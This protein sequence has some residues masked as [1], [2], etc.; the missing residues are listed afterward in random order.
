MNFS[1]TFFPW[2][3]ALFAMIPLGLISLAGLFSRMKIDDFCVVA[4]AQQHDAWGTMLYYVNSWSGS[5]TR[6]L[7]IG[8]LGPLDHLAPAIAPLLIV[9]LWFCSLS[10]LIYEGLI[11][12]GIA[13]SRR[14]AAIALS[15]LT[16]SA[17]I[18]AFPSERAIYWYVANTAYALPFAPLSAFLALSVRAARQGALSRKALLA[19]AIICFLSGGL[20]EAFVS[21]QLCFLACSLLLAIVSLRGSARYS[22]VLMLGAGWAASLAS[23]IL[24]LLSPGVVKR[25]L[26]VSQDTRLP[27]VRSLPDLLAGT[28]ENTFAFLS[29]PEIT[30]GFLLLTAVGMFY[31]LTRRAISPMKP[32]ERPARLYAPLLWIGIIVQLLCLPILWAYVSDDPQFFGRFSIRYAPFLV[33]NLIAIVAYA[34]I[35]WGRIRANRRLMLYGPRLRTICSV[36]LVIVSTALALEI[37]AIRIYAWLYLLCTIGLFL[38][39][40]IWDS[41]ADAPLLSLRRGSFLLIFCLAVTWLCQASVAATL[42]FARGEV[43]IRTMTPGPYLMMISGLVWG[44]F[45][46]YWLKGLLQV[47]ASTRIL[48]TITELA[49]VALILILAFAMVRDQV[50][51]VALYQGHARQW[52]TNHASILTMLDNG[53]SPIIVDPM[54]RSF[55][56][57]M[58]ERDSI[59]YYGVPVLVNE[60]R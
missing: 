30:S 60:E 29:D 43:F 6:F 32:E 55:G 31:M 52:D 15:A 8:A 48:K 25:S 35:L 16:V 50:A 37:T 53:E 26:A 20:A 44:A 36:L 22:F 24:Q 4:V 28:V 58:S 3:L 41:P 38:A 59:C 56:N 39:A 9:T 1:R 40:F 21:L 17:T 7:L 18:Y 45:L 13:T 19:G 12:L 14:A 23:L 57:Y 51:L 5:Y 47:S 2:L 27:P 46:G 54:P 49:L 11:C 10:W 42:L 34:A 33:L